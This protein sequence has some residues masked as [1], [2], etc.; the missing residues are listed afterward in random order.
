MFLH[1]KEKILTFFLAAL[2]ELFRAKLGNYST[3]EFSSGEL[4]RTYSLHQNEED[5]EIDAQILNRNNADEINL[6]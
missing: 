6:K 2:R 1:N 3:S 4:M 5:G